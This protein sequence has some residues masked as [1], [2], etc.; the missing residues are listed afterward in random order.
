MTD[1]KGTSRGSEER[2]ETD[3]QPPL[4]PPLGRVRARTLAIINQRPPLLDSLLQDAT[5]FAAHRL[6]PVQSNSRL[7]Q[8]LD[9]LR[10]VWESDD[11]L[12]LALFRLRSS[13]HAH[14]VPIL[15][16][17]IHRLC[18][19]VFGIRIGSKVVLKGGIYLPHG[20]VVIDG[21]VLIGRGCIIC[22]WVSIG[23][24]QGNLL[25]PEL[26]DNVFVGT[27]A[28][29]LGEFVIGEGAIIGAGAVVVDDVP[30]F[31]TVAGVPARVVGEAPEGRLRQ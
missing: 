3:S 19:A 6:E 7:H 25:G 1:T 23:L 5:A 22:P 9:A 14:G 20:N 11:Y 27:G 21:V 17:V 18:I 2:D 4:E 29:I 13:L 26:G 31:A 15:P 30:P 16:R 12:G 8:W 10:L 24:R 28:S